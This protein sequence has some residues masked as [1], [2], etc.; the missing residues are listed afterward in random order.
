MTLRKELILG[1]SKQPLQTDFILKSDL[2][3]FHF[4]GEEQRSTGGSLSCCSWSP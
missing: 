3:S 1:G 4:E 2:I